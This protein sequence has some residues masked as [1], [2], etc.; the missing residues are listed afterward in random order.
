MGGHHKH[1]HI[2]VDFSNNGIYDCCM[3]PYLF[4]DKGKARQ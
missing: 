1:H 2:K 4:D 3:L